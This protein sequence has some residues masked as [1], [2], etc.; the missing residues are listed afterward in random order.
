[1]NS[2][3][4]A[5]RPTTR[6]KELSKHLSSDW[7]F[8][9]CPCEEAAGKLKWWD[10]DRTSKI[11]DFILKATFS[12]HICHC[13]RTKAYRRSSFRVKRLPCLI[14]RVYSH[15]RTRSGRTNCELGASAQDNF[16]L[17]L[18]IFFGLISKHDNTLQESFS[19]LF[20]CGFF[21]PPLLLF[22]VC[23][24]VFLSYSSLYMSNG[25]K[26]TLQYIVHC[27]SF[28]VASLPKAFSTD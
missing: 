10:Q 27:T 4:A 19:T 14:T 8:W 18:I 26:N 21:F 6:K 11:I 23:F 3:P 12:K 2:N 9:R 15:R 16:F 7:G 25:Y 24:F 17:F 22:C 1:M 13:A 28:L 20:S 5:D